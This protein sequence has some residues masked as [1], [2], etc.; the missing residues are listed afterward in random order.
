M[1]KKAVTNTSSIIFIAKLDI[2]HLVKNLFHQILIPKEVVKEIFEKDSPENAIIEKEFQEFLKEVEVKSIKEISIGTGERAA[3]SYCL[4]NNIKTFLSDD[5]KARK[6]ADAL[7]LDTIGIIGILLWNFKHKNITK[8]EFVKL[9]D[10]LAEG[11][12]FMSPSLYS[13]LMKLI[14]GETP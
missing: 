4:E 13:E 7:G 3:I 14:Y 9:V 11:D 6:F 8:K 12:Y 10:A 1:E 2:F 5:K